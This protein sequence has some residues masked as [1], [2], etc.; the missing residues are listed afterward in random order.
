M[1]GS[2]TCAGSRGSQATSSSHTV[3]VTHCGAPGFVGHVTSSWHKRNTIQNIFVTILDIHNIPKKSK[4][5]KHLL[6]A[7]SIYK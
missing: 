6:K 7:Q 4:P 5:N 3:G 2:C 1:A